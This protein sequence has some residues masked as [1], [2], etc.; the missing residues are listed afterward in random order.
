MRSV[1]AGVMIGAWLSAAPVH[2]MEVAAD[3]TANVPVAADAAT[4]SRF[5]PRPANTTRFDYGYWDDA[6]DEIVFYGGPNL[7]LRAS[8]PIETATRIPFGHTSTYRL[9]GNRVMFEYLKD[10]DR[11]GLMDYVR[12][13]EAL[14]NVHDIASLPREEQLAFW[15][16]LHNAVVVA[17]VA[18]D[19][20][21]RRPSRT[22]DEQERRF[23]DIPRVTIAGV[24]LS[25]RDIREGI[26]YP[27]WRD[28]FVVY[29]FFRGDIGSPSIPTRAFAG[30]TVWEML[31]R[32]GG[33]YANGL[34]GFDTTFG[35]A[36]VSNIYFEAAP[37]LFPDFETDVRAHIRPLLTE[38]LRAQLDGQRGRLRRVP[39]ETT[40]AD[41]TG[42]QGIRTK[43][44]K[45]L[46][47]NGT[48]TNVESYILE[49]VRKRETLRRRGL[50]SGTVIIEDIPTVDP[51]LPRE[52]TATGE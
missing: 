39:Y 14:A 2:A 17:A 6:L 40:V 33:D 42:G 12:D 31:R 19:Y 20:K 23:H 9:E 35:P 15:L 18:D 25:L 44:A 28:P 29:G 38:E 50:L 24:A 3:T 27:N 46:L 21:V 32:L 30:G 43:Y 36:R 34:R 47:G 41:L 49:H 16:N 1:V 37:W 5:V 45:S 48:V 8:R 52:D 22:K 13:L 4:L 51:D 26:V 10:E 7:R 11:A